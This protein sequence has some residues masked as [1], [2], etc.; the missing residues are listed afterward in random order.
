MSGHRL[1]PGD[2]APSFS[3]PDQGGRT[4]RS[5]DLRGRK[6][7]VYFY[8]EAGSPGCT[9]Q[10]SVLRDAHDELA[11]LGVKVIGV[12]PDPPAA[13]RA[14]AEEHDL[15]FGLLSDPELGVIE[16]Y[17]ALRRGS[18]AVLRSALLLDEQ[19]TVLDAWY[20]VRPQDTAVKA[21]LAIP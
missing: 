1:K 18:R 4:V 10:A 3:L 11:N 7:L 20:G 8:P 5:E 14:F 12:S 15:P 19:G 6:V 2:A 9:A 21:A 13:Q 16:R 17:G